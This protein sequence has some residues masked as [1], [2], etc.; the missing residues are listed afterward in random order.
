MRNVDAFAEITERMGYWV[1]MDDA[2][3]TMDAVVHRVGVVVAEADL[4]PGAARRGPPGRAVLSA[5]RHRPVRPRARPGLRDRRRPL[6]LRPLPAHLR[7]ARR[8]GVAAGV[9]DHAVDAGLQ[10]RRRRPPR[11]HLR[12]GHRRRRDAGRRGAAVRAGAGRGLDRRG[13]RSPAREMERW[14][15]SAAVRPGGRSP[16]AGALRRLADYVTTE[17]GTG[18]VHQSPAFGEDDMRGRAARTACRSSTRSGRTVTSTSRRPAGRRPVLQARR[19]RRSSPIWSRA[20]CCSGTSPTST[21]TRT[22][23]AAT[24][25]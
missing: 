11:R 16:R 10:H 13:R 9:D 20:G 7:P 24:R 23:G 18:L 1:D 2:Y 4:R 21:P 3:R 12:G 6:G 8:P 17:D 15:Y 5:L 25:R 14:T 22:A 19:R